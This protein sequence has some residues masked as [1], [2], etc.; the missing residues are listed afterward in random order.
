MPIP[1]TPEVNRP[2]TS[3]S[4][5][6]ASSSAPR[7]LSAMIWYWVLCGAQRSGCSYTPAT[8]VFPVMLML[9]PLFPISRKT[10]EGIAGCLG[11]FEW[12]PVAGGFDHAELGAGNPVAQLFA[13]GDRRGAIV[14]AGQNQGRGRDLAQPGPQI[15]LLAGHQIEVTDA[16]VGLICSI[17]PCWTMSWGVWGEQESL[18]NGWG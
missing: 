7:A 9:R 6:P 5:R 15:N 16:R 12:Q 13:L 3:L 2:S 17:Q 11:L 8:A 18:V 10:P 4:V 14:L 1:L